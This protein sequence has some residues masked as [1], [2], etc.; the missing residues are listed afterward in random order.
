MIKKLKKH[1]ILFIISLL[2]VLLIHIFF[3]FVVPFSDDESYY[4]SV[5]LRL[6]NG[7][8]LVQHEWHLTQFSSLFQY[9]PVYIWTAIKGSLD[10]VFIFLR[11]I[12]LSI[13]TTIAVVVYRFFRKYGVWAVMTSM[14]FYVQIAYRIQAINYQSMFVIFLLLLTLCI[15]SI[16]QKTSIRLYIF[17]GLC[18]GCC[19]VCNPFFCFAFVLYLIACVLWT[20][21][22]VFIKCITDFKI[23][24]TTKK[25]K[26]LTKKQKKQQ[27]E[28][29]LKSLPDME[30]Y[31]CFFSKKAI[32]CFSIG[33]CIIAVVALIFF[34][35]TG[36]TI[37]SIFD[38][39]ENL[40]GSSEYDIASKSI[41]SKFADTIYFFSVANLGMPWIPLVLFVSLITDKNRKNN[42]HRFIYLTASVV[43]TILFIIGVMKNIEIYVCAI[44][45]PFSVISVICYLLTENK[46]KTLFKCMYIPCLIASVFHYLAADTHLAAIGVVLA[47][48]NVAGVF[49]ARDLFN[50]MRSSSQSNTETATSNK[51]PGLY[52]NI[53]IVGFCLQILFYGIF[54]QYGQIYGKDAPK[55]T[56]GP[57]TGLYMTNEEY[58]RYNKVISDMDVIKTI[59]NENDPVLLASYKNWVY[60]YLERPIATYTTWYRG[61]LDTDLLIRYYEENPEKIPKY[62]Y[63]ES[64]DPKNA[65]VQIVSELFDFTREDLSNGVLLTVTYCYF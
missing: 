26:Q 58:E 9:L 42:A 10:G 23:S 15:L 2:S 28:Q 37:D 47:V 5:P 19:C 12:Y 65:S 30:G 56:S 11:C 57:F 38:N 60:L 16:Y 34:F 50:E 36:G 39:M 3:L 33:I 21:R 41:F 54:Y 40:L 35:S 7:D 52:R 14:M 45:F 62:I 61:T 32:L 59:S 6:L 18:F 48:S 8:S 13:H 17:A 20:K 63:I 25:E 31:N 49:F 44:S 4:P 43:W 64:P 53:I 46:N 27:K 1:D 22:E 55:A 51:T 29:M 24:H